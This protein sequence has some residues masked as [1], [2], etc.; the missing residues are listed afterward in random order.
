MAN[1]LQEQFKTKYA[2]ELFKEL[3]LDNKMEV[4]SLSKIV[5]NMGMGSATKDSAAIDDAVEII[6][7]ITGQ[8]PVV[9][10]AR[11][12]IASFKLREGMPIGVSATLRGHRMWDFFDKL[13]NAVFPRVKDFRGVNPKAFDK[14]GNYSVGFDDHTIFPEI[15]RNKVAKIRGLQVT[16]VTTTKN[17]EHAKALLDK[18]NFPFKKDGKKE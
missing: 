15:D 12:S 2:D 5:V 7:L 13:V 1:R 8:K 14:Q 17:D 10:K 18:F 4:P 11:T 6:T 16:I 9:N 3:G